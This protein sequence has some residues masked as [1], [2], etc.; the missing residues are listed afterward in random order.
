[1]P[2][3][4]HREPSTSARLGL[5][6][7]AWSE[8]PSRS[9][10]TA[11][12]GT[13][14]YRAFDSINRVLQAI[15]MDSYNTMKASASDHP[16]RRN[17]AKHGTG[18]SSQPH[19]TRGKEYPMCAVSREGWWGLLERLC[20]RCFSGRSENDMAKQTRAKHFSG[21]QLHESLKS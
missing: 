15:Y 4:N 16:R 1:M 11:F 14:C 8:L 12:V 19:N 18:G 17:C 7:R 9:Q 6:R 5:R 10:Q 3:L 20:A 21:E 13:R 2:G